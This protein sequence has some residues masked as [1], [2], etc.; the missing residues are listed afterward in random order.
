[1][2]VIFLDIDGVL[3]TTSSALYGLGVAPRRESVMPF[4]ADAK[5]K[6]TRAA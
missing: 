5:L 6:L 4:K 2:K 1:M 3:N